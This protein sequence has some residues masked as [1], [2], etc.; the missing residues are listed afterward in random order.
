MNIG[1]HDASRTLDVLR[2]PSANVAAGLVKNPF[3]VCQAN[4]PARF[5]I[6][7]I[8]QR[9]VLSVDSRV[10]GLI[11]RRNLFGAEQESGPDN[12]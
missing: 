6:E 12:D 3:V 1:V 5:R 2:L 9:L 10:L 8:P 4:L 7:R 11:G